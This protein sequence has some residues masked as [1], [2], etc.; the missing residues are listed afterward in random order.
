[1]QMETFYSFLNLVDFL[2]QNILIN[3]C[4]N[5]GGNVNGSIYNAQ[6]STEVFRNRSEFCTWFTHICT[7][8]YV[9]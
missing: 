5:L 3:T 7:P 1:M 4:E 6:R 8:L 2:K 9:V